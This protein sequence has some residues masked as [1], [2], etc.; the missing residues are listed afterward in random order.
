M[1]FVECHIG[2]AA[3][4]APE[5]VLTAFSCF[6]ARWKRVLRTASGAQHATALEGHAVDGNLAWIC[7]YRTELVKDVQDFLQLADREL[8]DLT[9]ARIEVETRL[10][11]EEA[12]EQDTDPELASV[13]ACYDSAWARVAAPRF[14]AHLKLLGTSLDDV[15]RAGLLSHVFEMTEFDGSPSPTITLTCVADDR[16][17]TI[18]VGE[19]VAAAALAHGWRANPPT[20]EEVLACWRVRDARGD[21]A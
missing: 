2:L 8:A 21:S 1:P 16:A 13:L 4:Q 20:L 9:S 19:Q 5:S 14:E 12:S 18:A 7:T 11:T 17:G 3:H 15:R 6:G 10:K